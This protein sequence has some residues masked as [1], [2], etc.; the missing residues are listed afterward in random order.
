MVLRVNVSPLVTSM[1]IVPVSTSNVTSCI[2][3]P[4]GNW[5]VTGASAG[6]VVVN[7]NSL[8][9]IE[10]FST[11]LPSL[12]SG[13]VNSYNSSFTLVSNDKVLLVSSTF[14]FSIP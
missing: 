8:S 6:S 12:G 14:R 7:T 5:N 3:S 4:V 13:K 1:V 2:E 10:I 11:P 9:I